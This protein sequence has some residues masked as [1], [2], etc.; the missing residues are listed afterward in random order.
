MTGSPATTREM[1]RSPIWQGLTQADCL[2]TIGDHRQCALLEKRCSTGKKNETVVDCFDF[3]FVAMR[4]NR[5]IGGWQQQRATWENGATHQE[6]HSLRGK[7]FRSDCAVQPE[8]ARYE[9]SKRGTQHLSP[10]QPTFAHHHCHL[11][12]REV[13]RDETVERFRGF[14]R[15]LDQ[16]LPRRTSA[17]QGGEAQGSRAAGRCAPPHTLQLQQQSR[18][19]GVTLAVL[20]EGG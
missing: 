3:G 9:R 10:P 18:A 6:I 20:G 17:R 15:L 1:R 7:K 5:A 8:P 4:C 19:T 16:V 11:R 2:N 13:A 14:Y 12:F